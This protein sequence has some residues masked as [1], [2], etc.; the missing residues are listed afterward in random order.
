MRV[1]LFGGPKRQP[2]GDIL[3]NLYSEKFEIFK[4]TFLKESVLVKVKASA[5]NVTNRKVGRTPP[6]IFSKK[7]LK[8]FG[9]AIPQN[10]CIHLFLNGDAFSVM[11]RKQTLI[12][13]TPQNIPI[14]INVSS[15]R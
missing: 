14:K 12:V 15:C 1:N 3:N 11:H 13:P 2:S 5:Y 10:A 4:K 7:F 8:I 9:T 6:R